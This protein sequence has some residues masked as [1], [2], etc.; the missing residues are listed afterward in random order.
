MSKTKSVPNELTLEEA[1]SAIG[2]P[3]ARMYDLLCVHADGSLS[4]FPLGIAD[5]ERL[6]RDLYQKGSRIESITDFS[7][8]DRA[9]FLVAETRKAHTPLPPK[10]LTELQERLFKAA[11]IKIIYKHFST[12]E[13]KGFAL[14]T[15]G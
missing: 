5:A 3:T 10:G 8:E 6:L 15:V 7:E 12:R 13:G 9:L 4:V 14:I 1:I 2:A 11:A